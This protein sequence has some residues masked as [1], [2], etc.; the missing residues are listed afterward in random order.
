VAVVY[1][2]KNKIIDFNVVKSNSFGCNLHGASVSPTLAHSGVSGGHQC[3][4]A[5]NMIAATRTATIL[6]H[7]MIIIVFAAQPTLELCR[8]Q[9]SVFGGGTAAPAPSVPFSVSRFL[10]ESIYCA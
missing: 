8:G 9:L 7:P 1:H 2:I 6:G 3:R 10:E 5:A 4:M